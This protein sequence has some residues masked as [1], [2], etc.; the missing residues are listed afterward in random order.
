MNGTWKWFWNHDQYNMFIVSS[1]SLKMRF[2]QNY[3]RPNLQ[4]V[5]PSYNSLCLWLTFKKSILTFIQLGYGQ[6]SYWRIYNINICT[7]FNVLF[8]HLTALKMVK[9]FFGIWILLKYKLHTTIVFFKQLFTPNTFC[10]FCYKTASAV[11]KTKVV[12]LFWR[13]PDNTILTFLFESSC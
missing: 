1:T 8:G 3:Y 13:S 2:Y 7:Y 6:F 5:V 11:I 12:F 9:S 4:T 10:Y